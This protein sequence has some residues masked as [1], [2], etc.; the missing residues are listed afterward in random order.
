[1]IKDLALI[2]P[3]YQYSLQYIQKLFVAAMQTTEPS[4]L[5]EERL[6]FLI[7]NIT[8]VIFT[9]VCR[10]LFEKDKL[11]FSFLIATSVNRNSLLLPEQLWSVFLRGAGVFDRAKQPP[12][13]DRR[14]L[15]AP[16]WDLAHYLDVTFE[17]FRGLTKHV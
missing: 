10:G 9:S 4:D 5:L 1:M 3:M 7:Q 12:N 11:I 2:D 13:P 6:D 15:S 14:L 17:R 8:K 16:G